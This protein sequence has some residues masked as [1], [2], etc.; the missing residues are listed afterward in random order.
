VSGVERRALLGAALGAALL[1]ALFASL[2]G[3]ALADVLRHAALGPLSVVVLVTF[4]AYGTRA[5]R[6]GFLLAPLARV[7]FRRLLAATYLGYMAGLFVPRVGELLRPWLVGRRH[8][9]PTSAAFASIVLERVFDVVAVLAL[10]G[11]CLLQSGAGRHL[12]PEWRGRLLIGSLSAGLAA[13]AAL[14]TLV[15]L[16]ARPEPALRL[17]GVLLRAVPARLAS[18]ILTGVGS[19]VSGLAVLRASLVH[20]LVIAGQ[21]LLVWTFIATGVYASNQAFGIELPFRA[22]FVVLAFVL[23]GVTVPTPGAVGGFHAAYVL[24]LTGLYG[25]DRERAAAAALA[26]HGLTSLAVLVVGLAFL[27]GEGLTF[28]QVTRLPDR[29]D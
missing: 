16:H 21:S 7:P 12:D 29:A 2:R 18:A 23:V 28:R 22:A 14:S 11:A 27:P 13:L 19:F 25:V 6:F 8:A 9:I 4:G 20:L 1:A 15:A 17:L 10:A 3:P 24:A 5:W 26:C